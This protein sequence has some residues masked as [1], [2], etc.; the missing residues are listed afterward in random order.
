MSREFLNLMRDFE[1][2]FGDDIF[3]EY[4]IKAK[5][6]NEDKISA[7]S[8]I[9]SVN[10]FEDDDSY[11]YEIITPGLTKEN[12]QISL[13][14][15]RL[16]FEGEVK[17]EKQEKGNYISKEYQYSKFKRELFLPKNVLTEKITAKSENGITNIT[18]PKE[19]PVKK[20]PTKKIISVE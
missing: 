12:I 14:G 5:M 15:H 20:V 1:S 17:K 11:R 10:V 8:S 2:L 13:E 7:F 3:P 16:L 18:V 6:R 4:K 9:P 19:Q